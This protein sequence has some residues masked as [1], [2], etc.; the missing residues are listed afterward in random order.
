MKED[1]TWGWMSTRNDSLATATTE[2]RRTETAGAA[3]MYW[4]QAPEGCRSRQSG[5]PGGGGIKKTLA[6][7]ARPIRTPCSRPAM[8]RA[9]ASLSAWVRSGA[10]RDP[11]QLKKSENR[12]IVSGY[13]Y[14]KNPGLFNKGY[15]SAVAEKNLQVPRFSGVV[16][17]E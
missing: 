9:P 8:S 13:G 1:Y 10:A 14:G 16:F 7:S 11:G 5:K 6:K 17:G 12:V 2:R 15:I 3:K 4:P